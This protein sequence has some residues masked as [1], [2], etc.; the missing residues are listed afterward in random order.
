MGILTKRH[1][2]HSKD[3][4]EARRTTDMLLKPAEGCDRISAG[5]AALLGE[6]VRTRKEYRIYA[7]S[8]PEVAEAVVYVHSYPG[9]NKY[10]QLGKLAVYKDDIDVL[11]EV[12]RHPD[13]LAIEDKT[14]HT[15]GEYAERELSGFE[16][17]YKFDKNWMAGLYYP[18][19]GAVAV[20]YGILTEHGAAL[21]DIILGSG[22][23]IMAGALVAYVYAKTK[24]DKIRKAKPQHQ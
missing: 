5:D 23:S 10:V 20:G 8:S 9:A 1:G 19:V 17:R 18:A 21:G 13:V 16:K 12:F 3:A 24:L 6:L 14:W 22:S 2:R 4:L 7:V 11:L 15:F